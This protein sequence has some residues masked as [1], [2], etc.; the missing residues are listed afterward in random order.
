[1]GIGQGATL[2]GF[3]EKRFKMTDAKEDSI[4]EPQD[5]TRCTVKRNNDADGNNEQ[6]HQ[7]SS[8]RLSA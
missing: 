7:T 1:M 8:G 2:G 6:L 3:A 4:R 5:V